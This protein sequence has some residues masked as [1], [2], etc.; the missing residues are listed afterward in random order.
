MEDLSVSEMEAVED[1]QYQCI[2]ARPADAAGTQRLPE[3]YEGKAYKPVFDNWNS[4]IS[5][6][7]IPILNRRQATAIYS[8]ADN[9][10][11]NLP[12][13]MKGPEQKVELPVPP[14]RCRMQGADAFLCPIVGCD[15]G[16]TQFH[17]KDTYS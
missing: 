12:P 16:N 1:D 9:L 5:F 3:R 4:T 2:A 17:W 6:D 15:A 11:Y 14:K 8:A 13:L 7:A 10:N